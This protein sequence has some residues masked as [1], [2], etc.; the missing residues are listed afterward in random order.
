[1]K[2]RED[3]I[4]KTQELFDKRNEYRELISNRKYKEIL[5][6]DILNGEKIEIAAL[7]AALGEA[8]EALVKKVTLEDAEKKLEVLKYSKGVE[9]ELQVASSEKNADLMRELIAKIES[10]N[11]IIEPKILNDSKNALAKIK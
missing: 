8:K 9:E 6:T 5:L 11:L 4:A 7:E 2:S 10:E 1:M 3:F